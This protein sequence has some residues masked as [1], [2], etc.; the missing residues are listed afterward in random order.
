MKT[1]QGARTGISVLALLLLGCGGG[2]FSA[3]KCPPFKGLPEGLPQ[4]LSETGLYRDI[5]KGEIA[6]GI[7]PFFPRF[8][9]WSD[10]AAKRRW[11]ALPPGA[12]IDT[13]DM[14]DWQFPVGT[15]LWKEF[16]RDGV[17]V[18]T[19]LLQKIGPAPDDWSAV[20]YVWNED[21]TD[22]V[23]KPEGQV[24]ARGTR[25]DVPTSVECLACHGGRRS[26]ALG[27]SAIQLAWVPEDEGA[28]TL[29]RLVAEG[30]LT[31][32]PRAPIRV[33]GTPLEQAALGLLHANCG[34]CH[35]KRRPAGGSP[36]FD[37]A[38]T[39]IELWLPV[40][41]SRPEKTPAYR[42]TIPH[43]VRP[44]DPDDS[45]L[46][47]RFSS[48]GSILGYQEQMPPLGTEEVDVEGLRTLRR[49]VES[50]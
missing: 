36:C 33:P 27:F 1:T 21:E 38:G 16:V 49:W 20:A 42:T 14:D 10:G 22:A 2:C 30:R 44:G 40:G 5:R 43:F 47:E 41:V 12:R 18:E 11:I 34:H 35:N 6:Q 48:R 8:E 45:W 9:L 28:L 15:K 23:A 7:R 37:P 26:R 39:S 13:S 19:R 4:R 50:L 25:H 3:Q 46:L 31:H 17:R 32:P 29:D 24:D